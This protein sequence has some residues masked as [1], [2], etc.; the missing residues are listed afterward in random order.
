MI[1]NFFY[2]QIS[3]FFDFKMARRKS[4]RVCSSKLLSDRV[5]YILSMDSDEALGLQSFDL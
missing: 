5:S 4:T 1:T 3:H 2:F